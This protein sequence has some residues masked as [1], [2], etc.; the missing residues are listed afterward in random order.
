M[1]GAGG[2]IGLGGLGGVSS[3]L[4]LAG[5]GAGGLA[6][7]LTAANLTAGPSPSGPA[8]T[9]GLSSE[10]ATLISQVV[11]LGG[12]ASLGSAGS[13]AL[14]GAGSLTNKLVEAAVIAAV[15]DNA[16]DKEEEANAGRS[17]VALALVAAAAV[18]AY[19]QVAGIPG[20][21]V[22]APVLGTGARIAISASA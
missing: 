12:V 8:V 4:G 16:K 19:Q 11:A 7:R 17:Q 5:L 20:A 18:Q 21:T 14:T 9:L 15:L 13:Q 1:G 3:G 22:V 2:G 10:A 6:T